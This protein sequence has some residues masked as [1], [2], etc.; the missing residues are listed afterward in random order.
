VRPWSHRS[1]HPKRHIDRFSRFCK[2][3]HKVSRYFTKR[4]PF[5]PQ[6]CPFP[7]GELD[8]S[9]NLY[10]WFLE[11]TRVL[12]PN[13]ISI[14][15]AIFAGLTNVTDRQTDRKTDRPRY[16][17]SV[18]IGHIYTYVVL[19]CG[20]T[21]AKLQHYVHRPTY[22]IHTGPRRV[23]YSITLNRS[24]CRLGCGVRLRYCDDNLPSTANLFDDAD[25]QLF[26][27]ILA[28][29]EHLL[30]YYIV[31]WCMRVWSENRLCLG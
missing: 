3:H 12:N 21:I 5:P 4:R 13:C 11:P 8:P 23:V 15:S 9:N 17:P 29:G 18:T 22:F 14:G 1:P 31:A 26:R 28:N 6:N 19:R 20:L 25:N 2:A 27:N 10:T 16:T 30:H 24:R 7:L